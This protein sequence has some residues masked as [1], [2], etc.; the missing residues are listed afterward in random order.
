MTL[1]NQELPIA[2]RA[3]REAGQAILQ[4]Y[5]R[6]NVQSTLKEDRS[7]LTEADLA[8]N[9]LIAEHIRK[10]FPLDA[11]L[12]EESIDD[13]SR[14][15][16][17]RCWVVDPLD[18]T[19]EFLKGNGEFTVNIALALKGEPMLGVVL[20]PVTGECYYAARGEGA[21]LEHHGAVTPLATSSRTEALRIMTSRSHPSEKLQAFLKRHAP[22]LGEV[23]P[24]GSS[25]KGCLIAE[26]RAEL[27]YRFG[28]TMEWDTAAMHCIVEEAGGYVRQMD[29][30]PLQYNRR[31]SRNEKGFYMINRQENYLDLSEEEEA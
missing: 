19:K 22:K 21:F 3:A 14:L 30:S 9:A 4:I 1:Y 7:P 2:L 13:P 6:G 10:A 28:P 17:D 20:L 24:A 25:L 26:G 31:N 27:Y 15:G 5:Q 8:S 18:G 23:I 29:G 16:K 12:S 11:F